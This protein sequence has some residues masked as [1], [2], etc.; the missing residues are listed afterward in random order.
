MC[1]I[2]RP[3][4]PDPSFLGGFGGGCG[5]DKTTASFFPVT[6]ASRKRLFFTPGLASGQAGRALSVGFWLG[7]T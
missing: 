7:L 2:Q 3:F 6:C 1:S 4:S 5:D